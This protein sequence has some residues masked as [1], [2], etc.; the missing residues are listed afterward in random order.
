MKDVQAEEERGG[1]RESPRRPGPGSGWARAAW[2]CLREGEGE[3]EPLAEPLERQEGVWREVA[4]GH[5]AVRLLVA[6]RRAL[7]LEAPDQEVNAGA[8]VPAD[9]RGAAPGAGGQLAVLACRQRGGW[10]LWRQLTQQP[11]DRAKH[12]KMSRL[13]FITFHTAVS[14]VPTS[15]PPPLPGG[16]LL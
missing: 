12:G 5:L 14:M 2:S 1:G 7:A 16:H 3:V 6:A 8:A 15:A 4:G 13:R 9:A 11:G 10:M